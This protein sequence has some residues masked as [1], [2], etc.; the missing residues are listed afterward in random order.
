MTHTSRRQRRDAELERQKKRSEA[1]KARWEA[2]TARANTFQAWGKALATWLP[3]I[4][5]VIGVLG[6][7]LALAA[8]TF[9]PLL[10]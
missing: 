4:V 7:G 10:S 1:A 9:A 3:L 2:S 6:V 8:Q 5:R